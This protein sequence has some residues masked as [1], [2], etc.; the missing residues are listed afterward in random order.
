VTKAFLG[1]VAIAALL[2]GSAHAADMPLKA[3]PRLAVTTSWAGF[4][5]GAHVGYGYANTAVSLPDSAIDGRIVGAGGKG[6]VAGGLAGYNV[7]LSPRWLGGVEV[8]G[9]WQ[10]ITTRAQIFDG[11]ELKG[12]LDWSAS[13]R[14]R[15]GYLLTPTTMVFATAGWSWS[16]MKLTNNFG[17]DEF[18]FKSSVSGPQAGFGIETMYA[19]N[20]IVR[21]EYLHSF[22]DRKEFNTEFPGAFTLSPWVGVIRTAVIYKPG[23]STATAWPDRAPNPVWSGFYAGGL[24]GPLMANAKLSVPT[25]GVSVNGIGVTA[26][27]P[28][29]V[30]GYNI[31]LAPRWLAGVEGEI[32]PNVSTSDVKI[33]W[34]GAARVRAGYLVTPTVL[35]YGSIGWGTAGIK[36]VTHS[37][38]NIPIERVHG[39]GY[40]TGIEAAVSD[41]WRLRAD[42]QYYWTKTIDLTLPG[43]IPA[44]ARATAQT[45]RLGAIY[46]FG[47][48]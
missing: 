42:Y 29:L 24:L 1:G 6:W 31:L 27:V 26:F 3:S 15:L 7:M 48:P 14:A 36:N 21:T 38:L 4:Y 45:A 11:A 41:R 37:G 40:G 32:A 17:F 47:G 5:V 30:A 10:D 25:E 18:K 22:Y 16:A 19:E 20:W 8:D 28:S 9:S 2:A 23:P 12:S 35:T 39:F 13:A 43:A 46:A 33:E 34:T 44:S